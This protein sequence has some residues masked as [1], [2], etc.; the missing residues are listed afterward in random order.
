MPSKNK[1]PTE[2]IDPLLVDVVSNSQVDKVAFNSLIVTSPATLSIDNNSPNNNTVID[3]QGTNLDYE[4][5]RIN[6]EIALVIINTI[7]SDHADF[8]KLSL[9]DKIIQK[10][11]DYAT[12]T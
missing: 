12:K 1:K 6:A 11:E 2:L 9:R 7:I 8:M 10:I 5:S 4:R 3:N